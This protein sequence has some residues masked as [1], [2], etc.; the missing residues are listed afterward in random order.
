MSKSITLV[1]SVRLDLLIFNCDLPGQLLIQI[2]IWHCKQ[3][4]MVS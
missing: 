3:S 4:H 2:H 1:G